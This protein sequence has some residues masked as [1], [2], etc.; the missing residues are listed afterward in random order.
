MI[1]YTDGQPM[2]ELP[3]FDQLQGFIAFFSNLHEVTV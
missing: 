3:R 2:R 1:I